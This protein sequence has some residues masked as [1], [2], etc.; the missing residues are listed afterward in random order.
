MSSES[1]L[2][3]QRLHGEARVCRRVSYASTFCVQAMLDEPMGARTALNHL[4]LKCPLIGQRDRFALYALFG[5]ALTLAIGLAAPTQAQRQL[6]LQLLQIE[7]P[8][9]P[10]RSLHPISTVR[11]GRSL[12]AGGLHH[13]G[14]DRL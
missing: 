2:S 5:L 1:C 13:L 3:A 7:L 10:S 9:P 8:G 12:G 4:S 14:S 11:G 6:D